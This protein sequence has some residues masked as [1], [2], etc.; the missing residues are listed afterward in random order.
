MWPHVTLYRCM[1]WR[2][3]ETPSSAL[4]YMTSSPVPTVESGSLLSLWRH[5]ATRC[6][7]R[8]CS[9][10]TRCV[11]VCVC[12][13]L[14][15]CLCVCVCVWCV[16]VWVCE[17]ALLHGH[18]TW[19]P[20]R[21]LAAIMIHLQVS[22]LPWGSSETCCYYL[23]LAW[24]QKIINRCIFSTKPPYGG[25]QCLVIANENSKGSQIQT[26]L[27]QFDKFELIDSP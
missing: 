15:V 3:K 17:P 4:S 27:R 20:C 1:P 7:T 9:M 16:C 11:C 2:R 19:K 23:L 5:W 18:F 21:S 12:V 26:S 22:F 24:K 8:W 13:C 14:C 6:R 10:K 25:K